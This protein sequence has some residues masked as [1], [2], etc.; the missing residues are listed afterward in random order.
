MA[1]GARVINATNFLPD[2]DK[3]E[4]LDSKSRY[5]ESWNRYSH[6]TISLVDEQTHIT[7]EYNDARIAFTG[8]GY[9]IYEIKQ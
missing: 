4:I 8:D 6:Q 1:N 9:T 7:T 3:W 5:E 2:F